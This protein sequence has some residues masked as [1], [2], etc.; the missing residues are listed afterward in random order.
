MDIQFEY[1]YSTIPPHRNYLPASGHSKAKTALS[2]V[3][4]PAGKKYLFFKR[5]FD[6]PFFNSH[7]IAADELAAAAD[8][9][10]HQYGFQGPGIFPSKTDREKWESHFTALSSGP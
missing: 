8:S 4:L 9:P 5:G 7:F 1:F 2:G 3:S 10:A 6:I